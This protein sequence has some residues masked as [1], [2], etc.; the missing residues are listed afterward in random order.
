MTVSNIQQISE[1]S[2]VEGG[3][4]AVAVGSMYASATGSP[5]KEQG[6]GEGGAP[7]EE[8]STLRRLELARI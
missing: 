6:G 7:R 2:E 4:A 8:E 3:G 1:S 5:L